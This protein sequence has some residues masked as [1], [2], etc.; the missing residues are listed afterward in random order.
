MQAACQS[1]FWTL[2]RIGRPFGGIRPRRIIHRLA[3]RAFPPHEVR[4]ENM[5]WLRDR[6]GSELLLHPYYLVDRAIIAFGDYDG[7]LHRFL[8]EHVRPGMI[9][10]DIGANIGEM[11]LHMARLV[12]PHGHVHAFEPVPSVLA[13]LRQN[14]QRNNLADRITVHP[15]ALSNTTGTARIAFAE[16]TAENQGMGSLVTRDGPLHAECEVPTMTIDDF[17]R[18]HGIERIDL[19]KIDI[20]GAELL[21]LEGGRHVFGEMSPDLL[22]EVSPEDLRSLGRTSR[23]LLATVAAY[24]YTIHELTPR[25][26]GRTI[27]A[28]T[29]P[30]NYSAANVYCTRRPSGHDLHM[31]QLQQ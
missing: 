30:P 19:M 28:H 7:T 18:T 2:A 27:T 12:G 31:G 20:Q 9:C 23:D 3:R 22:M 17:V 1:L 14:V 21:L 15:V 24:G 13:R 16:D 11:A 6:W 25:G 29:V 4:P 26:P 8:E 10:L 5:R